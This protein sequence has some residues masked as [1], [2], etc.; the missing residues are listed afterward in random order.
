LCGYGSFFVNSLA[1]YPLAMAVFTAANPLRL[2]RVTTE[3]LTGSVS[4]AGKVNLN[5]NGG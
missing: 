2:R 5:E 1:Y 3:L 4:G